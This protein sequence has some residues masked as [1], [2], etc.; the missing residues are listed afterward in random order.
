MVCEQLLK[1]NDEWEVLNIT[2]ISTV[3]DEETNPTQ[4]VSYSLPVLLQTYCC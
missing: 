3:L 2:P 4:I 1:G